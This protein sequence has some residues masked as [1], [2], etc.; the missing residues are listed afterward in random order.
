MQK[1]DIS[2]LYIDVNTIRQKIVKKYFTD[3][4]KDV[5]ICANPNDAIRL[6]KKNNID[7]VI[8]YEDLRDI[9]GLDILI[10][11]RKYNRSLPSIVIAQEDN[12][13]LD[14]LSSIDDRN[15]YLKEPFSYDE[16]FEIIKSNF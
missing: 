3:L 11:L 1:L 10:D 15:D 9:S 16:L 2:I 4:V 12:K 7:L 13:Y 6:Y 5:V 8:I 14:F